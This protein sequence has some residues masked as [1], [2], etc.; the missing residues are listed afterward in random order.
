M[1]CRTITT[2]NIAEIIRTFDSD[3]MKEFGKPALRPEIR[4]LFLVVERGPISVKEAMYD[5][6]LSHRAFYSVL[7][8]L[9]GADVITLASDDNDGRVRKIRISNNYMATLAELLHSLRW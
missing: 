2:N 9:K 7:Q 6:S 3:F 4:L 1:P 5:S 8:R